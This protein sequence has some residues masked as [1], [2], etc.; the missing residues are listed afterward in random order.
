MLWITWRKDEA[1]PKELLYP[2][3]SSDKDHLGRTP[4]GMWIEDHRGEAIP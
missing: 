2:N 1:I 3:Y 4:L